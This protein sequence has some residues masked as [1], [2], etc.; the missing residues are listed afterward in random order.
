M[1]GQSQGAGHAAYLGQTKKLMGAVMI[2][3]PQDECTDGPEG[4]KFWI[5]TDYMTLNKYT[6][7]A[8]GD[9]PS[10]TSGLIGANWNKMKEAGAV[11][12]G[13]PADVG[14][15]PT[16][17]CGGKEHCSTALDDS[18]PFIK[19]TSGEKQYLY[20][21]TVWPAIARPDACAKSLKGGK[22]NKKGKKGKGSKAP[23]RS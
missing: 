13:E 3:G 6:A 2:S 10:Y 8:S 16:S 12:W 21:I 22:T 20:G 1:G 17:T 18:V 19:K 14:F 5:D 4:T 15:A 7:F 11:T 23:K 9:E